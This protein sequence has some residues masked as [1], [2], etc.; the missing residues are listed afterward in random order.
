MAAPTW[1]P[2]KEQDNHGFPSYFA[3]CLAHRCAHHCAGDQFDA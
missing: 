1:H 3:S 2:A